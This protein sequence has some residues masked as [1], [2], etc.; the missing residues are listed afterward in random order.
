MENTHATPKNYQNQVVSHQAWKT[1]TST[2]PSHP[3]LSVGEKIQAK[4][5]D[6]VLS[7]L[8]FVDDLGMTLNE[9]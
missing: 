5:R 8:V 3:S 4:P 9:Y 1:S 6:Y 7:P 2:A